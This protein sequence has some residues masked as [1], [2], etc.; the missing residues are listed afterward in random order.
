MARKITIVFD[1]DLGPEECAARGNGTWGVLK[2]AHPGGGFHLESNGGTPDGFL[3]DWWARQGS[4]S[5]WQ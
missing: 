4:E 2:I 3:N 1:E 5:P